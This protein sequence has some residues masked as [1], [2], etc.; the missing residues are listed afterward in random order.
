MRREITILLKSVPSAAETSTLVVRG[1]VVLENIYM[2]NAPRV[3]SVF[4]MLNPRCVGLE[5]VL[6]SQL[7]FA[8]HELD[9]N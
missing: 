8:V 4:Y 7:L 1:F 2:T 6:L 5:P 3:F 9:I